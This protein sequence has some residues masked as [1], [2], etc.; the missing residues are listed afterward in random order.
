MTDTASASDTAF[1]TECLRRTELYRWFAGLLSC[2]LDPALLS[3]YRKGPG[4][5][6]LDN[7]AAEPAL[8]PGAARMEAAL[9][10]ARDDGALARALGADFSALFENGRVSPRA[11]D[12]LPE[13]EAA[14]EGD[15]GDSDGDAN[16]TAALIG[17]RDHVAVLLDLMA[18]L[19]EAGLDDWRA[20]GGI[21]T[22]AAMAASWRRQ[23]RFLDRHLLSW[24]PAFRDACGEHD[25][26]GFYAGAA[27]LLTSYVLLDRA[28]VAEA[29]AA[30]AAAAP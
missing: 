15:G 17:D 22:G 25:R 13:A 19:V 3:A 26:D 27:M 2:R 8:R 1:I 14:A 30:C 24:L 7:L 21:P 16:G 23:A 9:D 11:S 5:A 28:L 10:V 6:V 18:Q 29:E 12:W 4:R 20:A